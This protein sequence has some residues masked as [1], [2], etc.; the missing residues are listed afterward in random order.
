MP[1]KSAAARVSKVETKGSAA[2]EVG[3]SAT[4][5]ILAEVS[6]LYDGKDGIEQFSNDLGMQ[7]LRPRKK[8]TVMIMGNHSAGKSSFINWYVDE[9]V[10]AAVV[11]RFSNTL[12]CSHH[13]F[14]GSCR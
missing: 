3:L 10:Q 7:L 13:I 6:D 4:E 5:R 2:D 11:Y 14:A 12:A 9:H 8:V 1:R